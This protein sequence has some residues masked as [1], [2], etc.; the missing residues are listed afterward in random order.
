M[1]QGE[2]LQRR[3]ERATLFGC[4]LWG[5]SRTQSNEV[6]ERPNVARLLFSMQPLSS[7]PQETLEVVPRRGAKIVFVMQSVV[8]HTDLGI[9]LAGKGVRRN[10]VRRPPSIVNHVPG[11]TDQSLVGLWAEVFLSFH[12]ATTHPHAVLL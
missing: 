1:Q 7:Q 3:L 8:S 2:A 4:E 12:S 6:A 9:A 11:T 10:G 5:G